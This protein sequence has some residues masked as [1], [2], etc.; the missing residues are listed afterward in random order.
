MMTE[1]Q[2]ETRLADLEASIEALV[3]LLK[4]FGAGAKGEVS[5]TGDGHL[6]QDLQEFKSF[7]ELMRDEGVRSY[8]EIGAWSGGS[9]EE[10]AKFLPVGSRIVAVEQPLPP[11]ALFHHAKRARLNQV[12]Q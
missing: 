1:E 2:I 12:L 8:L 10:A 4:P 11:Y 7:C 6:L 9:I 3:M 5:P